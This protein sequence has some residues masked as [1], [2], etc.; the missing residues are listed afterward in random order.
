LDSGTVDV[1]VI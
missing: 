1:D